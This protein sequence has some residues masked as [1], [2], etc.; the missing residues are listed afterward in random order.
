MKTAIAD[1]KR[2]LIGSMN[3][4]RNG[5]KQNDENTTIIH[6]RKLAKDATLYFNQLWESLAFYD[7]WDQYNL[8]DPR[9]E[10]PFSKNS[11]FDGFDNNYKDGADKEDKGCSLIYF[12]GKDR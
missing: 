5:S 4:S 12:P 1:K 2:L 3:W 6:H 8:R 9:P 11:C 7:D 10:S